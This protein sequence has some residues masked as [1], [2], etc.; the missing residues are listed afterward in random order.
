MAHV[1]TDSKTFDH[2]RLYQLQNMEVPLQSTLYDIAV[3]EPFYC[4]VEACM[5]RISS[6]LT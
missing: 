2:G 3:L 6:V 4:T 5:Q 1:G